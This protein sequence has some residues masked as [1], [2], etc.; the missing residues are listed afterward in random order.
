M[1]NEYSRQKII[2]HFLDTQFDDYKK[3]SRT[4][5]KYKWTTLSHNGLKFPEQYIKRNVPLIYDG[6]EIV[7]SKEAE[8]VAFLY[9]KYIETD[10]VSNPTFRKNF[11]NDFK[12][13][14]KD[15]SDIIK[16]LELCDFSLMKK[17]IDEEKE[18]K[19]NLE[20]DQDQ[21]QDNKYKTAYIDGK[22]ESLSN[23]KM[24]PP[25]IFIGRGKNPNI[26]KVKLRINPDD[27]IINISR[28]VP[29]PEPPY[30][31]WKKVIHDRSVEWLASWKDSVLGKTKYLWLSAHSEMKTSNDQKKFDL[32]KKLKKKIHTINETNEL[33]LKNSDE[34]IKQIATALYFIDKLALRVGNEKGDDLTADTVGVTNLRV[35]HIVL[36]DNKITLD[37]LGKDSI[38]YENTITVDPIIFNNV[39]EFI[40]K[41][42]KD[43]QIFDKIVSNDINKYL[44]SFMKNLTAKVFRTF[45][46]SNLFQ[47]E[48][49]KITKKYTDS[50]DDNTKAILDDF[51]KA[52]AKVA[53]MMNHQKNVSK[54][55]KKTVDKL[56]T[57]LDNLK[58]K[59]AQARRKKKKNLKTIESI[60][61]KIKNYKSKRELVKEMKNISLG[62]SKAN[63]IDPRITVA[64]M[65]LHK[66]DIN[67][68]FSSTLQKKFTWAFSVD[69]NYKF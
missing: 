61:E 3:I 43:E 50:I 20:K 58:K 38:R 17:K 29:V 23:Y 48:L 16:S 2:T 26:G 4:K 63:Y 60:K 67:K 36:S 32:A 45:N 5:S 1:E 25:G 44:Q 28:D 42:T 7:L 14:L 39:K 21:D 69:E 52:N 56:N 34:K 54:G 15:N 65:K 41:K 55:Y 59:L 9:A 18:L 31:K 68:I 37:F 13:V 53:K 47:K 12:K 30:G 11:F 49:R 62:T 19:T 40:N 35:E 46:A 6:K 10:Y 33:N 8:E 51:I 66:L 24:E 22:P 27:V 57:T 64:F